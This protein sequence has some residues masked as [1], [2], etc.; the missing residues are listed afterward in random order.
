MHQRLHSDVREPEQ[1]KTTQSK[2]ESSCSEVNEHVQH[3]EGQHA[4]SDSDSGHCGA[5]LDL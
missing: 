1:S 2:R 4:H 3:G 5:Q